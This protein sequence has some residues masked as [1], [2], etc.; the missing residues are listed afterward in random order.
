MRIAYI[1][2]SLNKTGPTIFTY[3]LINGVVEAGHE[4]EVFYFKNTVEQLDFSVKCTKITLFKFTD[5]SDFDIVHSTMAKPDIYLALHLFRIKIPVV[6]GFHCFMKEDL[7]QLYGRIKTFIYSFIW[8]LALY[9]IKNRIVSSFPMK[10]YYRALL[11]EDAN[12][13]VECIPYGIPE[14][15]ISPIDADTENLLLNLRSKYS[16]I[17]VGCGSLIKRKGFYQMINYLSVNPNAAVVLIG[18]GEEHSTLVF[19]AESLNVVDRVVFLGFRTNSYNYYPYFDIF[20]MTSNSEGFG[21]A[22]LEAMSIGLPVVCSDL[23][24]YREFFTPEQIS[25]FEFGNQQSF[26]FAVDRI[27]Q[28]KNYFSECSHKLFKNKF[29]IKSMTEKHIDFYNMVILNK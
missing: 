5:F 19:Q 29:S 2:P 10:G 15:N 9:K 8:K 28:R 22:M 4:C 1:L 27:I 26:N 7:G 16:I 25:L 3:N 18:E 13:K 11:G 14:I 21:L 23:D 24:I 17:L 20:C 6:T 12:E